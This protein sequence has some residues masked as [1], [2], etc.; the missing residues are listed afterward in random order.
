MLLFIYVGSFICDLQI[1][2]DSSRTVKSFPSKQQK[3][4]VYMQCIAQWQLATSW[5]RYQLNLFGNGL[6]ENSSAYLNPLTKS[7]SS[8]NSSNEFHLFRLVLG[9]Q[10]FSSQL[11]SSIAIEWISAHSNSKLFFFN[12]FFLLG[13]FSFSHFA[14]FTTTCESTVNWMK[15]NKKKKERNKNRNKEQ[16]NAGEDEKGKENK[17]VDHQW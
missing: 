5:I 16:W 2:I 7:C 12:I 14:I 10:P 17:M 9:R 13:R 15:Q 1:L 4:N 11:S 8:F 6:K 3:K